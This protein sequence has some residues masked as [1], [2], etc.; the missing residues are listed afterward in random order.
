MISGS[1]VCNH[2]DKFAIAS[3]VC[4]LFEFGALW[5][6]WLWLLDAKQD[7]ATCMPHHCHMFLLHIQL[8]SD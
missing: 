4:H 8:T 3:N 2:K 6:Q 1:L 7:V 5:I